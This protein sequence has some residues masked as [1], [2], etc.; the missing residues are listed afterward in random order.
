MNASIGGH[1]AFDQ[2]GFVIVPFNPNIE[3]TYHKKSRL[4]ASRFGEIYFQRRGGLS[5]GFF[6][7]CFVS[8]GFL[9]FVSCVGNQY[10][11]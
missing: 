7:F 8:R 5:I 6:S 2:S 1:N 11:T 3:H 10:I 4:V 9:H